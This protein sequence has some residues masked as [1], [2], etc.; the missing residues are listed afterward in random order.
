MAG[1]PGGG[2]GGGGGGL[3]TGASSTN[4]TVKTVD[5]TGVGSLDNLLKLDISTY[6]G[7]GTA[8]FQ[9]GSAPTTTGTTGTTATNVSDSL[10]VHSLPGV[11]TKVGTMASRSAVGKT[12]TVDLSNSTDKD[13]VY[14]TTLPDD[15]TFNTYKIG[16]FIT[17][18]DAEYQGY[19]LEM[20]EYQ[21]VGNLVDCLNELASMVYGT[22]VFDPTDQKYTVVAGNTTYTRKTA[23]GGT[24]SFSI[25]ED[26]VI[27]WEKTTEYNATTAAYGSAIVNLAQE[28]AK[29]QALILDTTPVVVAAAAVDRKEELC[30]VKFAFGTVHGSTYQPIPKEVLVE[31]AAS[32]WETWYFDAAGYKWK[33]STGS[34]DA[35]KF[36][37]SVAKFFKEEILELCIADEA[38]STQNRGR[39]RGLKSLTTTTTTVDDTGKS[40]STT[41]FVSL[42]YKLGN[43]DSGAKVWGKGFVANLSCIGMP[44][45]QKFNKYKETPADVTTSSN[46]DPKTQP[47]QKML[48]N[49]YHELGST[50]VVAR[51]EIVKVSDTST[52][53]ITENY[54]YAK[55]TI[56][57]ELFI[58]VKEALKTTPN[59]VVTDQDISNALLKHFYQVDMTI[60]GSAITTGLAYTGYID[61]Y[62]RL[63]SE[64][65]QVLL[66]HGTKEEKAPTSG[67]EG[68][69]PPPP[70]DTL[71][72]FY[73]PVMGM[74]INF[75]IVEKN[76]I[77]AA[78]AGGAN[79]KATMK[80]ILEK[81]FK[82]LV[83]TLNFDKPDAIYAVVETKYPKYLYT[84]IEELVDGKTSFKQGN[85]IGVVFGERNATSPVVLNEYNVKLAEQQIN[86]YKRKVKVIESK[87]A[88]IAAILK[89]NSPATPGG[90]GGSSGGGAGDLTSIVNNAVDAISK[91]NAL[92]QTTKVQTSTSR[93][94]LAEYKK[95]CDTAIATCLDSYNSIKTK[96]KSKIVV[97]A[98]LS[99][100][101]PT[102]GSTLSLP[103]TISS[104]SKYKAT[105]VTV[106]GVIAT[107]AGEE[108]G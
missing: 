83:Q 80:E 72:K 50:A 108:N 12:T 67:G 74:D 81:V 46:T 8:T 3:Q 64:T 18:I 36:T 84:P 54:S 95:E 82:E 91:Y 53:T 71:Y 85:R 35:D 61:K 40:T 60:V 62:G 45:V 65:G 37:A 89:A 100:S 4:A 22:V 19:S 77:S 69:P 76:T 78:D 68:G 75:E 106:S 56:P 107:I 58:L 101:L 15:D 34:A 47:A 10:T 29:Y 92:V 48:D 11:V 104:S 33:T 13:V 73:K 25:I 102:I 99:D 96:N 98:I 32:N 103:S 28:K 44:S 7:G 79:K 63:I 31:T 39:R 57:G 20:E 42:L 27:S 97:S 38:G 66:V 1:A 30:D 24:S 93:T 21:F 70:P 49:C 105:S 17:K 41:S 87:I 6:Q 59:T 9:V 43:V 86:I 14:F 88:L 52:K 16:D 23:G 5:I 90:G 94:K 55:F 2:G 51:D 26:D